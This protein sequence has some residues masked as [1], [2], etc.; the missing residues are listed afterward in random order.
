MDIQR[1]VWLEVR[2]LTC[3]TFNRHYIPEEIIAHIPSYQAQL[4]E[5]LVLIEG[6]AEPIIRDNVARDPG[7]ICQTI[8][9]LV[10]GHL[11]LNDAD[12]QSQATWDSL[13]KLYNFSKMLSIG[14]LQTAMLRK[15]WHL[16]DALEPAVFLAFARRYYNNTGYRTQDTGR[17]LTGVIK[18]KLAEF[19]PRLQQTMT[20]KD[21]SSQTGM[22]GM[23]LIEVLLEDR[24][25]E[26]VPPGSGARVKAEIEDD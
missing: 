6:D 8:R 4:N 18:A 7:L 3:A 22:L 12:Q 24:A 26:E 2:P 1:W 21:I 14:T 19:L 15:F 10:S 11:P 23:Q 16:I 9:F 17:S 20:V 25:E 5:K 13:V